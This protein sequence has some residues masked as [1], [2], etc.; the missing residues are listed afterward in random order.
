MHVNTICECKIKVMVGHRITSMS[1]WSSDDVTFRPILGLPLMLAWLLINIT[2]AYIFQMNA[3][4]AK[5]LN[6]LKDEKEVIA[7]TNLCALKRGSKAP[8]FFV[9]LWLLICRWIN[10]CSKISRCGIIR[11]RNWK[12]NSNRLTSPMRRSIF[13]KFCAEVFAVHSWCPSTNFSLFFNPV[14]D[15]RLERAAEGHHVLSGGSERDQQGI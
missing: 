2:N 13:L 7:I 9:T 12:R 6:E 11:S 3:K 14:G 4:L 5:A 8:P 10:A 15:C 1:R